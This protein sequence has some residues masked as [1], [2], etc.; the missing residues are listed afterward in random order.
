MGVQIFTNADSYKNWLDY[1][2]Y[3]L[4][5]ISVVVFN[6]EIVVTYKRK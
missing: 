3:P 6:D 2:S 1:V 4:E 5:I